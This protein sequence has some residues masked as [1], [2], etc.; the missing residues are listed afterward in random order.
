MVVLIL[1]A[2]TSVAA[3]TIVLKNGRRIRAANVKEDGEHVTYETPAGT[4]SLPKSI[5]ARTTQNSSLYNFK[6]LST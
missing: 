4:M 1:L 3:D 5:V 2:A 6:P